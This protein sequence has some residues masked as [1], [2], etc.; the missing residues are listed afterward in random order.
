MTSDKSKL[1]PYAVTEEQ[2]AAKRQ[3]ILG[4]T[5][6]VIA[7]RGVHRCSFAAVATDCGLSVGMIQHYFSSRSALLSAAIDH[8]IHES[9]NEW[10]R[11]VRE[12]RPGLD[13]LRA[14]VMFSV[15]SE[16]EFGDGWG[17]WLEVFAAARHDEELAGAV[18]EALETW[19][20]FFM[21]ALI[22]AQDSGAVRADR[23]AQPTAQLLLALVDGLAMQTSISS[24]AATPERMR[25]HLLGFVDDYLGGPAPR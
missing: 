19:R 9:E 3:A 20:G 23:P 25:E 10:L 22:L 8:R 18:N 21:R 15:D 24:Y 12:H 16:R 13:Q 6:A 4:S 1:A 14:L 11:I 5:C 7:N 2:K 17:F